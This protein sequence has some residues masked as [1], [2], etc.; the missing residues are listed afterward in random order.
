[1][2]WEKGGDGLGAW[3]PVTNLGNLEAPSSLFQPG[4]APALRIF[5]DRTTGWKISPLV[6]LSVILSKKQT[7]K[8]QQQT[9]KPVWLGSNS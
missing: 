2:V 7:N 5:E 8:Q 9:K 3:A 1:M 4:P 6:F